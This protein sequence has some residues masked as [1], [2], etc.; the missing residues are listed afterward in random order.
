MRSAALASV[1]GFTDTIVFTVMGG[2]FVAHVT[3]NFVLL[4]AALGGVTLP[5]DHDGIATLQILSFPIFAAGV[6]IAT[7]IHDRRPVGLATPVLWGVTA[8]LGLA[9]LL[10]ALGFGA[11]AAALTATLAMGALNAAQRLAPRLGPPVTVMTGNT[12]ALAITAARTVRR[13]SQQT[14]SG[15]PADLRTGAAL[16]IGFLTGC[17]AGALAG[18]FAGLTALVIPSLVLSATLLFGRDR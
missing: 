8:L 13:P 2:L 6:G 12:T 1:A 4:G 17:A 5:G 7:I 15:A 10:V 16:V 9:G 14:T 11:V 18:A 3:G